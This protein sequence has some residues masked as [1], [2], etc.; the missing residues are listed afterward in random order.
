MRNLRRLLGAIVIAQG[1][2]QSSAT[3]F[4][5]D[6]DLQCSYPADVTTYM[7]KCNGGLCAFGDTIDVIGAIT[8]VENLPSYEMCVETK[9]C[10][11]GIGFVCKTYK[12][13][14]VNVCH[15]LGVSSQA[16]GTACPNAG[17]FYFNSK[18]TLPGTGETN[19]GSG[20]CAKSIDAASVRW[21]SNQ[22]STLVPCV[23][24]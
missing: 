4:R 13:D 3:L 23:C 12:R 15:A 20:E 2:H 5:Y 9:V 22:T 10:L 6:N 17:S 24:T 7:A 11:L 16:D 14:Y 8:L 21:K 1:L 18:V 19:L